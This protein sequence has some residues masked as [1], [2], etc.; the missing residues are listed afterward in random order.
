MRW[1]I[2]KGVVHVKEVVHVKGFMHVQEV[3]HVKGVLMVIR[4]YKW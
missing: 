2:V 1:Q 4:I 3:Q